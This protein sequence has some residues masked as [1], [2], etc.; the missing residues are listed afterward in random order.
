[1]IMSTRRNGSLLIITLW[2]VSI[3][4]VL[5][6]AIA[7]YLSLDLRLTKYRLALNQAQTLARSG[8]YLG[9]Q[10]LALDAQTPEADGEAYDWLGDGWAYFP[11]PNGVSDEAGSPEDPGA[12]ST[13]WVMPFPAGQVEST[14]FTGTLTIRIADEERKLHV[15]T[16]TTNHLTRLTGNEAISQAIVDAHDDP[17]TAEDRP[18]GEPPYFAKNGP[19]VAPEELSDIPE[20]T[21]QIYETLR[22]HTSPYTTTGEPVNLNTATPEVIGALGLTATTIQMITQFR[23]GPD[24]SDAHEQDGIFR[25]PGLAILQ[26]LQDHQGVDLR[27][28]PD[29]NL[30]IGNEFGVS[31]EVFTVS[32]EVFT[33]V[34]EGR[35]GRPMVRVRMEAVVRRKACGAGVPQPCLIAWRE[36]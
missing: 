14:S 26:T 35:T 18:G 25:E 5:V 12:D 24:G 32:S 8:I 29:G 13:V 20:M 9:M 31:S 36:G 6:V 1:M 19:L 10:R 27:G 3:L 21:P 17:D 33:V 15:N 11:R 2:L 34:A 28:T 22:T 16:A 4:A 7:R 30:L 23:E